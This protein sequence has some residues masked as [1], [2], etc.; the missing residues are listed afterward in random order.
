[1]R[2]ER[3]RAKET[4]VNLAQLWLEGSLKCLTCICRAYSVHCYQFV[5]FWSAVLEIVVRSAL[6]LACLDCLAAEPG[7]RSVPA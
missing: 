3:P 1:M 7:L 5:L 4:A 2:A 6:R